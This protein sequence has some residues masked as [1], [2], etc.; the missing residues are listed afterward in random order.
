M[1]RFVLLEHDLTSVAANIPGAGTRH[2][3][4]MIE[5][6]GQEPLATWRLLADPT[7]DS[8]VVAERLSDHR[9]LYLDYEGPVSGG[10]GVVR[11]VD[12]G[13]ALLEPAGADATLLI[14]HGQQLNDR[15]LIAPA[16]GGGLRFVRAS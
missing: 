12:A 14:L 6:E 16:T 4:L 11:R 7:R 8:P 2:W 9:R 10:R 5:V 13:E 3:D 15:Y 1:P